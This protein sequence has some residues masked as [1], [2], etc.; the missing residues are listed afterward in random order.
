MLENLTRPALSTVIARALRLMCQSLRKWFASR[1][2]STILILS[3]LL[4]GFL[5]AKVVQ[6]SVGASYEALKNEIAIKEDQATVNDSFKLND[7]TAVSLQ[8]RVYASDKDIKSVSGNIVSCATFVEN[9]FILQFVLWNVASSSSYSSKIQ[10]VYS[11]RIVE[12]REQN[13]KN[14]IKLGPHEQQ[15]NI[16]NLGEL[17]TT[18]PF[19]FNINY[20]VEEDSLKALFVSA[21]QR[22]ARFNQTRIDEFAVDRVARLIVSRMNTMTGVFKIRHNKSVLLLGG[23]F[24]AIVLFVFFVSFFLTLFVLCRIGGM[25]ILT[26][27]GL[28]DIGTLAA[29]LG[30]SLTYFGLLG[31][32]L[33][34]FLAVGELS[35]IDFVDE[36]KKV[37]DQTRSFGAMSL[38]LGS[39]VLGLGGALLLWIL[40]AIGNFI[41]RRRV[42]EI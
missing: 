15:P 40:Q 23:T 33:G 26:Q 4:L 6:V 8:C 17:L 31:T 29:N 42:F 39:S 11:P 37:F 18:I 20:Y 25:M 5:C 3:S 34:I 27:V 16:I 30:G 28:E 14:K 12:H 13:E 7:G 24:Q 9:D 35:A 36:M 41:A 2:P 22:G 19:C 32:L 1:D 38:A 21:L 10:F